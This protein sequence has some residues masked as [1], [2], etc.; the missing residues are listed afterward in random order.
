M[1]RSPLRRGSLA[2]AVSLVLG[3]GAAACS[4]SSD[5]VDQTS[6]DPGASK[7]EYAT[8][9]ADMDPV[10]LKLQVLTP[11]GSANAQ[12][13]D[14]YAA[15]VE[16]LS[17]GKITFKLHYSGSIAATDAEQAVSDGLIDIAPIHPS[18][19]PD[20]FPVQAYAS[21]FAFMSD[22]SPI[23]GSLQGISAWL[24]AGFD[25]Q[26]MDEMRSN[27]LE[28]LLPMTIPS[29]NLMFCGEDPVRS[30]ADAKKTTA[31]V[32]TAGNSQEVKAIG[33]STVNLP[34]LEIFEGMQRG[35]VDCVV[36]GWAVPVAF[37][38]GEVSKSWMV[39]P[40]VQFTGSSETLAVGKDT[41]DAL[42]LAARQLMWDELDV[43]LKSY[44]D[45]NLVATLHAAMTQA[46]EQDVT[47]Y[48]YDEDLKQALTDLH[49]QDSAEAGK[50]SPDG[51]DGKAFADSTRQA[52][53][54]WKKTI[55]DLGYDDSVGWEQFRTGKDKGTDV[56]VQPLV[57]ELTE[58]VLGE[59]RP[60]AQ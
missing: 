56:D 19:H 17:D 14:A 21:N 51:F 1:T 37:G 25:E 11:K 40:T 12:A 52:H 60:T 50:N 24:E 45:N 18:M 2:T 39:D 34:T 31:R 23:V 7:E 26:I 38:L 9:L 10:E 29:S 8:A 47:F 41:W 49:E 16:E 59:H 33:A 58:K 3:L 22:N 27:G 20:T 28:P 32:A 46:Q 4:S 55:I 44:I 57:D 53:E 54:S 13:T 30:L 35:T 43:Y 42:P 48:E 15:A 5:A 36:T 6:V